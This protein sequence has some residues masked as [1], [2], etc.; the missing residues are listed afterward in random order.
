M[1]TVHKFH[2]F[3]NKLPGLEKGL[4]RAGFVKF[5][6]RNMREN[7]S[8]AEYGTVMHGGQAWR[9]HAPEALVSSSTTGSEAFFLP[10]GETS[11]AFMS[12]MM[13]RIEA[14]YRATGAGKPPEDAGYL[15]AGFDVTE[16]EQLPEYARRPGQ[17][18]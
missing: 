7:S 8:S 13:P 15:F 12:T 1:L 10:G 3:Q 17:P 18:S 9:V 11:E 6:L 2:R 16:I 4:H 14:A 5:D